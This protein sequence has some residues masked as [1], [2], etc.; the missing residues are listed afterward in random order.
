[1]ERRDQP[2]KHWT[3]GNPV[4]SLIGTALWLSIAFIVLIVLVTAA[5][6]MLVAL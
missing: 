5:F 3:Q 4:F 1:M 6:L 2:E